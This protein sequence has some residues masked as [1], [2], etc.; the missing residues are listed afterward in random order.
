MKG[1]IVAIISAL[2]LVTMG[3]CASAPPTYHEITQHPLYPHVRQA[4]IDKILAGLCEI[5]MNAQECIIA[6]KG[7]YFEPLSKSE[8]KPGGFY[9]I[10]RVSHGGKRVYLHFQNLILVRIAEYE[11]R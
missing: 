6:W 8:N 5:G 7:D 11:P 3:A 2:I 10:Y 4:N 9:D 1:L